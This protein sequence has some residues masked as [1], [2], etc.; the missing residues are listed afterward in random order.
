[1]E[2]KWSR[3]V[4]LWRRNRKETKL[5]LIKLDTTVVNS[6]SGKGVCKSNLNEHQRS[7]S[8]LRVRVSNQV[9]VSSVVD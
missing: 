2:W 4:R 3:K 7:P 1:M 8:K 9:G 6:Q 5:T